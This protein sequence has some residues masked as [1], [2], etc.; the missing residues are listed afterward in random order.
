[1]CCLVIYKGAW[2]KTQVETSQHT[3]GLKEEKQDT[4]ALKETM[5]QITK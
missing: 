5:N 4:T 2:I 1:M 3:A